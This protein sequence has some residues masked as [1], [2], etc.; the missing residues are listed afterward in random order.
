V[1]ELNITF[2]GICTHIH[3]LVPGVP[4]RTVLPDATAL[5]FG[6][7]RI[8][9]A[10]GALRNAYYY[11]MPHVAKIRDSLNN[12][13]WQHLLTGHYLKVI[14]AKQQPFCREPG[15]FSLTE[16]KKDVALSP[17]VVFEGNAMAYFDIFG[18]R[19]WH[20]GTGN[21]PRTTRVCIK[22]EGTPQLL[23]APLPGT[24]LPVEK[25]VPIETHELYV[26]NLDLEAATEDSQFDF[27]MNY[28]VA[29]GGIPSQLHQRT[30]G[31]NPDP[32][33]LTL[34]RVGERMK[35]LGTL[36]ETQGT[37]SGWRAAQRR[38]DEPGSLGIDSPS[39]GD[40]FPGTRAIGSIDPVPFD[41]SCSDSHFP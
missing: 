9:G 25:V 12:P 4:M 11:L 34:F 41:Q 36:I 13:G 23:I 35:A 21:E 33:A 29:K 2:S 32:S 27:L 1:A 18:G 39:G 5:L 16:F 28:L 38:G 24:V 17:D 7:V 19:V 40:P 14:N 8:P 15:G 31:M 22:T 3:R 6:V 20:E 37:V 26:S 10:D 30:P